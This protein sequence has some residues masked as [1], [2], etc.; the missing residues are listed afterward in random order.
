MQIYTVYYSTRDRAPW[1]MLTAPQGASLQGRGNIG[2]GLCASLR[3][4][5]TLSYKLT[6]CSKTCKNF[7]ITLITTLNYVGALKLSCNMMMTTW[8]ATLEVHHLI[9][10][11]FIASWFYL[12]SEQKEM[13]KPS[14]KQNMS[15]FLAAR[16]SY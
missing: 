8:I 4:D 6:W 15:C 5:G 7:T 9:F 2:W 13:S 12:A 3:Q 16:K 14:K 1:G 11:I 10:A